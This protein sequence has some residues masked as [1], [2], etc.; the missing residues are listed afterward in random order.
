MYYTYYISARLNNRQIFWKHVLADDIEGVQSLSLIYQS[1]Y[2]LSDEVI[3]SFV[4]D[5]DRVTLMED[6]YGETL[7]PSAYGETILSPYNYQHCIQTGQELCKRIQELLK[8]HTLF[9]LESDIE[10]N[11]IDYYNRLGVEINDIDI[12]ISYN[13]FLSYAQK[14]SD[15]ADELAEIFSS[16]V[17]VQNLTSYKAFSYIDRIYKLGQKAQ[18]E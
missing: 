6:G 10:N 13:D 11:I 17:N 9:N 12:V 1:K 15:N 2:C 14:L 5:N 16:L 8:S 7:Y 3:F 18:A 4:I